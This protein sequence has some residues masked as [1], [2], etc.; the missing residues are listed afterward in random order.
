[1][2]QCGDV[3]KLVLEHL[4]KPS[5]KIVGSEPIKVHLEPLRNAPPVLRFD[6]FYPSYRPEDFYAMCPG[7][8][9]FTKIWKC[10]DPKYFQF[11]NSYVAFFNDTNRMLKFYSSTK[12]GRIHRMRVSR[13][14]LTHDEARNLVLRY[15]DYANSLFLRYESSAQD[16]KSLENHKSITSVYHLHDKVAELEAASVLLRNMP[17][18]INILDHFW[19]HDI[20]C[21][22]PIYCNESLNTTLHYVGFKNPWDCLK[23]ADATHGIRCG[24]KRLLVERFVD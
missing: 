22:A 23:F 18:H 19:L 6:D 17:S 9:T 13:E 20:K 14:A 16:C 4:G 2:G 5:T 24:T 15:W 8:D 3:A 21:T 1:M 11:Q 7:S 10:R 12:N